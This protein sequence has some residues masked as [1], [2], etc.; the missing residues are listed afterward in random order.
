MPRL[1]HLH[2]NLVGLLLW[3]L[4]STVI[5]SA[6]ESTTCLMVYNQGGAPAVFQSPK[7]PRWKLSDYDS[8]SR[9]SRCQSAI[10]QGR[11][12]YQEDR[13]LCAVDLRIP[14]PGATGLKE[15]VVGI[16]AIFDGHNGSEASD[17]ASKLLMEYLSLHTYFL[18][19]ATF[20]SILKRVGVRLP[21]HEDE[22][23]FLPTHKD[24]E[25]TNHFFDDGRFKLTW[26]E[27]FADTFRLEILKESLLRTVAD[28][29]ATFSKEAYKYNLDSG[30]TAT[31]S[32]IVDGQILVA[33]IGDSKALL[34]SERFQSPVEAKA[35]LLRLHRQKRSDGT[36][37]R[38]KGC[39]NWK[40]VTSNGLTHLFARELTRDHRPD[41]EDEKLRVEMAGG[42]VTEWAGVPRVNGQLAVSR[43]IGDVS[44]KRYGVISAPEVSDWQPL[45]ANDSYL[46][47]ASDGIFEKMSPQDVCD[48][49]WEVQNNNPLRSLLS[50]TCS[51]S[52]AECI[53]NTAFERGSM[54]NMGAV[55]VPL[56]S[57]VTSDTLF[58]EISVGSGDIDYLSSGSSKFMRQLVEVPPILAQLEHTRPI[59]PKFGTLLVEEKHGRLGCFYLAEN[60]EPNEEYMIRFVEDI[61]EEK[62]YNLLSHGLPRLA[63]LHLGG[64]LNLYNEQNFCF[65]FGIVSNGNRDQCMYQDGLAGFLGLLQSIPLH[66]S[67]PDFEYSERIKPEMRYILKKRFGRGAYGEVWLAFHWNCSRHSDPLNGRLLN[68]SF[69]RCYINFDSH[70]E[71]SEVSA[72][73]RDSHVGSQDNNLFI[74]KRIMVEKGSNVYLSGLREKYF[75]EMFLNASMSLNEFFVSTMSNSFVNETTCNFDDLLEIDESVTRETPNH[76]TDTEVVHEEGLN[77]IARYIESFESRANEIW[78]VFRHEGISL[79][80]LMYTAEEIINPVGEDKTERG[81]HAHLLRPS[82]WWHW[83]KTTEAGQQQMRSL[84]WQLLMAL[85]SC[86]DRNITHRDIKPENMV[87]C[88]EDDESGRCL[89]GNI[90]GD[91]KYITN[92]RVIDFGSGIDDFSMKHLY[93]PHGPSRAEQTYEYTPPEALLNSSW[94]RGPTSRILKY[95]MWSVGVIMLELVLGSPDVFQI[96]TLSRALLDKHVGGWSEDLKDLAYRLRSFMDMCILVS[97]HTTRANYQDRVSPASWKCSEEFFSNLIRARDP[98][99]IGF[100]NVWAMRLVRQLLLWDPDDRLSVDDALQH[101]YFHLPLES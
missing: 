4:V 34:C 22:R 59:I 94:Y 100:P 52:L 51:Y 17:M 11:R 57:M 77:H 62:V 67:G 81:T 54:D 74:L 101:P 90:N 66:S 55:V 15:A 26:P 60:L 89:K 96:S 6:G 27:I 39:D 97:G 38:F 92:M 64:A 44:F 86:H 19:D 42:Y 71:D 24:G 80:K 20:S 23:F 2:L 56:K 70:E 33:N 14:F 63:T 40:M 53:V 9:T 36:I 75:G 68:K 21:N 13:T 7:C 83:L 99:K 5:P 61:D 45:T 98:L 43:A 3:L 48:L 65:D 85:K 72:G 82:E 79:S 30:S 35:T 58:N 25:Q 28:I 93:G 1:L 10:L 12:R 84:I 46:I 18:L 49:L 37:S 47:V 91:S 88:I 29:D 76:E 50:S 69:P 8:Q 78:L 31:V 73:R 41:R 95:D 32:L 16:V 87:I